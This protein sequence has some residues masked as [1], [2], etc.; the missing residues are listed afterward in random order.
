M[1]RG[2]QSDSVLV[3]FNKTEDR[4]AFH[5]EVSQFSYSINQWSGEATT[6]C[7]VKYNTSEKQRLDD[8]VETHNGK[9]SK[10]GFSGSIDSI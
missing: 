9:A 6:N 10:L 5:D 8:V 3:T 4:D 1:L 7:V 2:T